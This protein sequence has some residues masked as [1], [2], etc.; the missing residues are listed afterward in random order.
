MEGCAVLR[1]C[2]RGLVRGRADRACRAALRLCAA[3]RLREAADG[4]VIRRAQEASAKGGML[5]IGSGGLT[6]CSG[7]NAL[8]GGRGRVGACCW[9]SWVC[10][11]RER[12]TLAPIELRC[13][14]LAAGGFACWWAWRGWTRGR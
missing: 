10:W 14:V 13:R 5:V 4:L 9:V 3:G 1:G 11:V 12:G 2:R 8:R 7:R 6:A